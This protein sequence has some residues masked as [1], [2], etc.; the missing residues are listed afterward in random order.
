MFKV[1]LEDPKPDGDCQVWAD[2]AYRSQARVAGLRQ[3]GLNHAYASVRVRVE[4]VFASIKNELK[5]G[6]MTCLGQNRS[7]VWIGLTN[8]CY[9]LKLFY[10]LERVAEAI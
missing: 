1:L 9:N 2:S 10:Y 8:L 7:R 5:G 3:K 4:H 6:Y